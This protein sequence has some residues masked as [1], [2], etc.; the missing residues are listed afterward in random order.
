M[1][2]LGA[3]IDDYLMIPPSNQLEPPQGDRLGQ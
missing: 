2:L 3:S 1:R